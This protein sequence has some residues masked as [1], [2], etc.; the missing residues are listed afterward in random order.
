MTHK[1]L[2]LDIVHSFYVCFL[3][4][5][6]VLLLFF[7]FFFVVVVVVVKRNKILHVIK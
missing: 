2:D 4:L 7:V 5:C 6:F 1:C 3:V